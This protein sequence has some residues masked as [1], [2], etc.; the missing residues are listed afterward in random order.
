[1]TTQVRTSSPDTYALATLLET[2]VDWHGVQDVLY[3][4]AGVLDDKADHISTSYSDDAL[5][6]LFAD[7]ATA[8]RTVGDT[9]RDVSP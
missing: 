2:S 1:M 5:A 3:I 6:A 4:L 7:G 8:L 9:F